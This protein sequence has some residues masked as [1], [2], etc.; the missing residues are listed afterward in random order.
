MYTC[1]WMCKCEVHDTTKPLVGTEM[2]THITYW[3]D[4]NIHGIKQTLHSVLVYIKKMFIMS[5][6]EKHGAL[7]NS[8]LI[9]WKVHKHSNLMICIPA[10][11]VN[12]LSHVWEWSDCIASVLFILSWPPLSSLECWLAC[13]LMPANALLY[14]QAP[15]PA[16]SCVR[17][18]K[19]VLLSSQYHPD[20]HR[21]VLSFH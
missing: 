5:G 7:L 21:L 2:K 17:L 8:I 4:T 11:R 9:L 14:T 18:N 20:N 16:W 6:W 15:Y 19:D 10:F 12:V 13:S 1:D 3:T